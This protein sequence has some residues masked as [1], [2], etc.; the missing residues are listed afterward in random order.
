MIHKLED[1]L[2]E[3]MPMYRLLT[4]F[5]CFT[6]RGYQ[7]HGALICGISILG[8]L[9]ELLHK[10]ACCAWQRNILTVV[11]VLVLKS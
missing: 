10:Y 5:A 3:N 1:F 11:I 2:T 4:L 7:S 9:K 8:V 6:R